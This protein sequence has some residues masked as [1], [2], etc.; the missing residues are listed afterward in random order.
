MWHIPINEVFMPASRL[1]PV[2][3][4]LLRHDRTIVAHDHEFMEITVVASGSGEHQSLNGARPLARGSVVIVRPGAW[5]A[6]ANCEAMLVSNC[7]FDAELLR[8]DLAWVCRDARLEQ[9]FHV[10]LMSPSFAGVLIAQLDEEGTQRCLS[11]AED[12]SAA[13]VATSDPN[14]TEQLAR[15]ALFFATLSAADAV[16]H[17]AQAERP[18]IHPAVRHAIRLMESDLRHAW[19]V[20]E[21]ARHLNLDASYLTRLFRAATTLPPLAYYGRLRLER[22]AALLVRT[23]EA[24]GTVGERVGF[25]DQNLFARRFRSHYGVSPSRYRKTFHQQQPPPHS[26]QERQGAV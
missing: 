6:Y 1:V 5:H 14:R 24:I 18:A 19:S 25:P 16:R 2:A 11:A 7:V 21:L 20:P 26:Q 23:D 4:G 8:D 22:A 9:L 12:L 15:L 13:L 17:V 3:A 10:R